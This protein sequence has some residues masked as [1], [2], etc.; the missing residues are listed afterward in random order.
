M[1]RFALA[2]Y[3]VCTRH[4]QN[5]KPD[6]RPLALCNFPMINEIYIVVNLLWQFYVIIVEFVIIRVIQFGWIGICAIDRFSRVPIRM[7]VKG[8]NK[9]FS[10][11]I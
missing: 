6:L 9:G 4:I 1:S 5:R 8:T 10:V 7:I 2:V 11:K 3:I